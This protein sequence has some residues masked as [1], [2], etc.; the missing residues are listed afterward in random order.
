[1]QICLFSFW[2]GLKSFLYP[3]SPFYKFNLTAYTD[4]ITAL[5]DFTFD[6]YMHVCWW[7]A[8]LAVSEVDVT[9]GFYMKLNLRLNY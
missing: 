5:Y 4:L 1:M 2:K 9:D 6:L 3:P 8:C 7:Q